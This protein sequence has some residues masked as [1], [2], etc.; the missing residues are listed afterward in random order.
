M[1]LHYTASYNQLGYVV[2]Y[3]HIR[4]LTKQLLFFFTF[5]MYRD[6]LEVQVKMESQ[7]NMA[8]E[9][10]LGNKVW[11]GLQET[12]GYQGL[13]GYLEKWV[14]LEILGFQEKM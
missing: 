14:P 10:F 9:D 7:G 13:W 6:F 8:V 12:L 5:I 1:S 3:H 11:M 2:Q 4:K